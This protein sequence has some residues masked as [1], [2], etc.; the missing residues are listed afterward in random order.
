MYASAKKVRRKQRGNEAIESMMHKQQFHYPE[1]MNMHR[2]CN[3]DNK[4]QSQHDEIA[5][6]DKPYKVT[7]DRNGKHR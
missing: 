2:K 7:L 1:N 3:S 5:E 4:T 6:F